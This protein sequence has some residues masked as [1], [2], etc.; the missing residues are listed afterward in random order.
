V[1]QAVYGDQD[2]T[3]NRDNIVVGRLRFYGF[4]A[5]LSSSIYHSFFSSAILRARW[6]E[7]NQNR[8]HAWKVSTIWKCMMRA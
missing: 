8:P 2:G 4:T 3:H 6:T 1:I 5:I 7:L